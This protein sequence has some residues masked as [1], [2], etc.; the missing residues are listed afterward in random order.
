MRSEGMEITQVVR[1]NRGKTALAVAIAVVVVGLGAY[2]FGPWHLF[3]NRT[4]DEALPG[5]T[6]PTA[7][8]GTDAAG[9]ADGDGGRAPPAGGGATVLAEGSFRS[10]AH[11]STGTARLVEVDGAR[12]LRLEDLDVLSGPDLRVYLTSAP[13]DAEESA[14]GEDRLVADLGG[15]R[16]NQGNLTYEIPDDVDLVEVQSVSVWCRRFSV[17]FAVAPLASSI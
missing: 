4:A 6:I 8:P 13:G 1:R 3:V 7:A 10:L 16:A 15:L 17:G 5:V 11:E 12:F 14:F 2:W 9:G